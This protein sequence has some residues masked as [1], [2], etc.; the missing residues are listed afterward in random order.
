[1]NKR[2][3]CIHV[4]KIIKCIENIKYVFYLTN[5]AGLQTMYRQKEE[6][7]LSRCVSLLSVLIYNI[8]SNIISKLILQNH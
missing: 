3:K 6:N 8:L 7:F 2:R 1:M 5:N 4:S